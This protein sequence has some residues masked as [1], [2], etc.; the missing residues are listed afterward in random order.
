MFPGFKK[1]QIPKKDKKDLRFLKKI[2]SDR[3]TA[4]R[5]CARMSDHVDSAALMHLLRLVQELPALMLAL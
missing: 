5:G 4:R 1:L 2:Y 3:A